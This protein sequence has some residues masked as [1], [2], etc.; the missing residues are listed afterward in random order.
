MLLLNG[1]FITILKNLIFVKIYSPLLSYRGEIDE[2][3]LPRLAIKQNSETKEE[4]VNKVEDEKAARV[5]EI[6]KN[7]YHSKYN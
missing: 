1:K 4:I 7:I 6:P 3:L 5:S 2:P